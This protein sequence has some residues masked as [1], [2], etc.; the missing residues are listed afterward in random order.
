[1]TQRERQI[2]NWIEENPL[3]SQQELAKKAGIT[4]SSV[5]VHISNLMKKGY[6]TGKGYIVHTAPYV[7]VVGGVNMDI[8]GWPSEKP[9][10]QDS[11]PGR[12][13]MSLGG[14][15]RNIAHNMSLLGLDVRMLTVFGDDLYAQ[16]IAASC[17]ELGIDISQSPVIPGGHTSTYLFITDEQGDMQLAVSDMDIYQNL[18]PQVLAG[19]QKLLSGSQ[20]V[21][22]DTNIPA[23]SIA[24]I[25]ENC[26]VPVFADP[27][28]TA[29]AVKLRPVLGKLH[30]L[31][32][33]RIEAELLSGVE[34][35]DEE[36][37]RRAAEALLATGLRRI[38]ISLGA[39]GV[40]AADHEKCVHLPIL[41]G[42]MVNTTGCGDA[43]MAA[44]TW[45]YMAGTDLAHTAQAG[46]AASAIA[47]EGAA[48]INPALTEENLMKRA[49]L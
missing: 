34:I 8:G 16:K 21:V 28:S 44:I 37:L 46:L 4:R 19:H 9:V 6:I 14:V 45:A 43:F 20:V 11:N 10:S 47:M 49:G 5:A 26:R 2:M 12:V 42:N 3:I 40:F 22:L 35:R 31:K 24:W 17:G 38:F 36:T 32:P 39:D 15:G 33:N 25:A 7:T 27:V 41:P 18:T 48:T 13:R 1:M 29:K 30:T 23:E